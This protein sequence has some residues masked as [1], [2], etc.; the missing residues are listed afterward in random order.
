MKYILAFSL[1][2]ASL[3]PIAA[4]A[5]TP[6][7]GAWKLDQTKSHF[8]GSTFTYTKKPKG[9][10]NFSD[11]ANI[12][13][14]FGTD[15]KPYKT[16]DAEDTTTTRMENDHSWTYTNEFK[17]KVLSKTHQ[18][19]S[20]DEKTITEH[21][22]SYRP[23]GSTSESDATYART[24]GTKGFE[25]KWK[26]AK[27]H[28]SAPDS[29]TISSGSDGT[30]TWTIPSQEAYVISH[31]KGTP[32]PIHGPNSPEGFTLAQTR[33]G[34]RELTYKVAVKGKVLTEGKMSVAPDGKTMT[35]TSWSPGKE[36]EK[37]IGVYIK[38]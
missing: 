22:T 3:S 9:L 27:V 29:Y 8:E 2:C 32:E 25:G 18:E 7:D 20:A 16:I 31:M 14:D 33:V 38:Q 24:S 26:T 10:W 13:F 11:G 30:M 36:S 23:D 19:V 21:T 5:V 37:T 1:L 17:G 15:G 28:S 35:D 4:H 12:S 6:W 34:D